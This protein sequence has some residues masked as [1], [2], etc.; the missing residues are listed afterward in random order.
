MIIEAM[1]PVEQL[2]RD[3]AGIEICVLIDGLEPVI[4]QQGC[5]R[6]VQTRQRVDVG[7]L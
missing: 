3:F 4:V 1:N 7:Q 5:R 6:A 2:I